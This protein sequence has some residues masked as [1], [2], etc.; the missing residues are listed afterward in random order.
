MTD[1]EKIGVG[2]VYESN[3][4]KYIYLKR[5]AVES[6]EAEPGEEVDVIAADGHLKVVPQH[7]EV[8][9]TVP[10]M[11]CELPIQREEIAQHHA[12]KHP[13]K[14]YDPAWYV[15]DQEVADA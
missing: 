11:Y 13:G 5:A 7:G 14:R 12:D 10:C 8:S 9:V 15:D 3:G 6:I 1:G 2:K 4:S